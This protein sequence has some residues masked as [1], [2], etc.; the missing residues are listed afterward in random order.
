MSSWQTLTPNFKKKYEFSE[1][2]ATMVIEVLAPAGLI[3]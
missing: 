2:H 3:Y 1:R